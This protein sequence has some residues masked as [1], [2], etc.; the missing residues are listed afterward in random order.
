MDQI[1]GQ[2]HALDVLQAS[3]QSGRMHHAL[4]FH[5]PVGVGKF[6]TAKALAK[7]LLCHDPQTELTGRVVACG[8]C[9]SCRRLDRP[10]GDDIAS[11]HPDFHVVTKE[12]ARYS[13]N[14]KIQDAKLRNIPGDVLKTALL[15]PVYLAAQLRHGKVFIVDEAELIDDRGQNVLLKT[16]EEPPTGT[17]I[18]LVTSSEDRLL[19]TI[20][21]RCQRVGFSPLTHAQ[22]EQAMAGFEAPGREGEDGEMGQARSW[23]AMDGDERR[24]VLEFASG[25]LGRAQLAIAYDLV[26]WAKAVIPAIRGMR[27]GK[28]PAELGRLITERIDGFA[29]TWVKRHK[30]ASKEAANRQA[31]ALMWSLISQEAS[32]AIREAAGRSTPGDLVGSEE[33]VLPWLGVIDALGQAEREL[34]ANVNMGVACDHL[35]SVMYRSLRG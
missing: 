20:R 25:S 35:V 28:F 5:G 15:E 4:I 12:L 26:D 14:K 22:I 7:V 19:P 23:S 11:T 31:G 18:I 24:W 8:A 13:E 27:Q 9:E 33:M 30:N 34:G 17:Y 1:I 10:G 21:S 2:T 6:T 16:L 29:Q 3:L 32:G